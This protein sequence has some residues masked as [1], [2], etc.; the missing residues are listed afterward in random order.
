MNKQDK[1]KIEYLD[2]T[3]NPVTGCMHSCKD[4]YCYAKKI[5]HR[6]GGAD[7]DRLDDG[8]WERTDGGL[9]VVNAPLT[10]YI[11]QH[12]N[13]I[14]APYPFGFTPTFHRYRLDEPQKIKRPSI[15]GVVYMGD[16]FGEWVPDSWIQEVFEACERAPWHTYLFLTKNPKRYGE[17][18]G[19]KGV[20]DKPNFWF[21]STVT[22]EGDPF[23]CINTPRP[24][25]SHYF[26]SIEPLLETPKD[27]STLAYADLV[28]IGQQ[29]NPNKPPND[30]DVQ[31]II[32]QCKK[33]NVPVFVKSP[34]YERYPI[35]EWP[36]CMR[37]LKMN[38]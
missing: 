14:K 10:R 1:E 25:R 7:I 33:V 3:W 11:P 18:N 28:I 24:H 19:G 35:Q 15:I 20:P 31:S 12:G 22:K 13:R 17:L 32:D 37:R 9:Y 29:T 8:S 26:V 27:L 4:Q 6:F 38:D 16:L 34:L 23:A 30:E 36:E 2:Y 5:A 21:G